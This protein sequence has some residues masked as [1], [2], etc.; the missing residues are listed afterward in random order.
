MKHI[1]PLIAVGFGS[2]FP[3]LGQ[4]GRET[5]LPLQSNP[6]LQSVQT[7][8]APQR[9]SQQFFKAQT[10]QLFPFVD[11]FDQGANE[12][13]DT[14]WNDKN[15]KVAA[16]SAVFNAQNR[17]NLNYSGGDGTYGATDVL[18]SRDIDIR[19][20]NRQLFIEFSY[21][22]GTTW[23]AGDS[24]VL[25][26][27]TPSGNYTPVWRSLQTAQTR[28][29]IR[30][31]LNYASFESASLNFKF[32]AYS[33]R[34]STQTE[35]FLVH[36]VILANKPSL[37]FYETGFTAN[38]FS[39]SLPDEQNWQLGQATLSR[40][41]AITGTRGL[42]FNTFS[43]R[44]SAYGN[45]Y[46]DTIHVQSI[47]LNALNE[48]DSVFLNFY[49][50]PMPAAAQGDSL[51]MEWLNNVGVWIRVWQRGI[52]GGQQLFNRQI[53]LG[54]FRH[55][56]F[57]F[58]MFLKS[59]GTPN[60][61]MQFVVS[62]LS[63]G[64]K[65]K[66]PF[67][68]DFSTTTLFPS[69]ARWTDKKVYINNDFAIKPPSVNVATFDGLDERG[70]AYGI[71]N[72]YLDSLTSI[73]LNLIGLTRSDSVYLSFMVQ[74]QG[75]GDLPNPS[76]TLALEFRS[77]ASLPNAWQR[78]WNGFAVQYSPTSFTPVYVLVDSAFLHHDF[79]F[80]FRNYGSR[81]GNIDN[82][83]LDYVRM[84]QG[85]RSGD[86]YFDFAVT[87]NP[88]S[89]LNTYHSMPRNHFNQNPAGYTNNTQ[90]FE[91]S[92]NDTT[93]FPLN[94]GRVVYNPENI[95]L[96]SFFNTQ[97]NVAGKS[98]V[99][100][101]AN[102]PLSLTTA[103]T[104]DSLVFNT[105]YYT[106]QNNNFDNIPSNDAV[107][108]P[109]I[110]SNYFAYDDGT[111]EAGYAIKIEPGG[112]ALGYQLEVP[113]VLYGIAM[114]FNQSFADVSTQ[115]FKLTVWQNI[116]T[117]PNGTGGTVLKQVLI[118]QPVYTGARNGFF[119]Y[120]FDQPVNLPAG[121]FYIG[122]EQTEIFQLNMGFDLNYRINGLPAKN[123]DM[124]YHVQDGI[125]GRT[126]LE[127]A[128][129]M[130]PIVGKWIDPP[131]GIVEP[132]VKTSFQ[133]KMYP[134]PASS[135]MQIETALEGALE[136]SIRDITGKEIFVAEQ[137]NREVNLQGLYP[138]IYIVS[139]KHVPS[140]AVSTQKLLIQP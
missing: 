107:T 53:N 55:D 26:I 128:L 76:D 42:L 134:N 45:G 24:L 98:I 139:L 99:Q 50:V 79:Q 80:R 37:P 96:D 17:T 7:T 137:L 35:T 136:I 6:M 3:V 30:L 133:P 138:G 51:I 71:G 81:T 19:S 57:Q 88:P 56:F 40:L 4:Q 131:V 34:L 118:G 126:Q 38:S 110:F 127:G 10:G 36:E 92:N 32:T 59:A 68:D 12:L 48:A 64:R 28:R 65:L 105:R 83:H 47:N 117:G 95:R 73:P 84:D 52:G 97:P 120:K 109:T 15:V 58:R 104:T 108:V 5:L 63:I 74:P 8:P 122:W 119:Y 23:Q 106:N 115:S 62:G 25:E 103:Q 31:N 70:N 121:K 94:F 129:M 77:N 39:D 66:L 27:E 67:V 11:R 86:G 44:G 18:L 132:K 75:W 111:A 91:M 125:W 140:G 112:V 61:T 82:W 9:S 1:L 49:S 13:Q 93:A 14:F 124:W 78:V 100:V 69:P 135:Y 21:S 101:Q 102:S 85:R 33:N 72:G 60:D 87:S 89:L 114:F 54:R 116:G 113:D 2:V 46:G 20:T 90:F 16:E 43:K 41:G 123:P 22:T 29:G 130:R